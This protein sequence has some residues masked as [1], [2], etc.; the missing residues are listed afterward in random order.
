MHISKGDLF[1]AD[2]AAFPHMRSNLFFSTITPR[3]MMGQDV[4]AV[5]TYARFHPCHVVGKSY[6]RLQPS[7]SH[8]QAQCS[9]SGSGSGAGSGA[10]FHFGRGT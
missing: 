4:I 6:M 10:G 9:G 2:E 1:P 8:M 5:E 3:G 7:Q